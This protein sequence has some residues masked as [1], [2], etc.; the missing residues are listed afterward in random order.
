MPYMRSY[1]W[2]CRSSRKPIP[3]E[4]MWE[5]AASSVSGERTGVSC[6]HQLECVRWFVPST[7]EANEPTSHSDPPLL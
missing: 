4:P 6:L 2:R 5:M 7:G 1:C 3:A